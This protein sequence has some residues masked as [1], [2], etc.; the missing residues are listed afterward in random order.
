M[1]DLLHDLAIKVSQKDYAVVSCV[2]ANVSDRVRHLMWD[3]HDLS[4]EIKFPKQLQRACGAR[5]FGIRDYFGI[6]SKAFLMDLFSAF[7]HLRVLVFSEA[8]FE[9]LPSSIGNLRHLRYLVIQWNQKIKY[10]PDTLCKLVNLQTLFLYQCYQ[11]MELPRDV[12]KLVNLTYLV[13]TS[14]QEHLL[15]SE[16]CGWLCLEFLVLMDCQELT[17]L[18]EGLGSLTALREIRIFNCPKLAYLPS[19]MRQ[20]SALCRLRIH[21]CAELDLMEP[22]EA[23]SG[24]CS[25]RSL[26]VLQGLPKLVAF[27]DSFRS[28]A[29]SIEY[30][31]QSQIAQDWRSCQVSSK[32]S[33][34]LR[35]F[36]LK[37]AQR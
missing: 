20:L 1:H 36:G 30:I 2:K 3:Q 22:E 16:F 33:L 37:T 17:S 15:K 19:S 25:L 12:H 32:I 14:K 8:G 31:L 7:K 24:L 35:K 9:E 29:L 18:T 26:L 4:I 21:D 28:A 13:L 5:S 34:H 27:P 11:L 10:L 23:L 6:V